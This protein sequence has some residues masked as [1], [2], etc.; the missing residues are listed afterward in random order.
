MLDTRFTPSIRYIFLDLF[1]HTLISQAKHSRVSSLLESASNLTM[2]TLESTFAN[3]FLKFIQKPMLMK[4]QAGSRS[5]L[6][7]LKKKHFFDIEEL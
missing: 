4:T 5:V 1:P 6:T 7:L 3:V 2:H